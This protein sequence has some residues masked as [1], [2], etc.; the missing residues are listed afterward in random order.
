MA[1]AALSHAH[2]STS[3]SSTSE[4]PRET[5]ELLGGK[6]VL[7][8]EVTSEV[9][10]HRLVLEGLPA[11]AMTGLVASLRAMTFDVYT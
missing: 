4:L 2:S 10:A 11:G 8:D 5:A 3:T 6:R 7:H 9:E 1:N